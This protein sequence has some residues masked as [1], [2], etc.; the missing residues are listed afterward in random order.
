MLGGNLAGLPDGHGAVLCDRK[1]LGLDD[2]FGLEGQQLV[3]RL[4]RLKR[5]DCRLA[6]ADQ[7]GERGL[8]R[9]EIVRELRLHA[10]CGAH[11]VTCLAPTLDR[12]G[13]HVGSGDRGGIPLGVQS[14][15]GLV[16]RRE[17]VGKPVRLGQQLLASP[18]RLPQPVYDIEVQGGKVARLVQQHL[19]LVVQL[20]D[21][22]VG[23]LQRAHGGE[24][25]L[26]K[27]GRIDDGYRACASDG[28]GAEQNYRV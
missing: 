16:E 7:V 25:V 13:G 3:G 15:K 20:A 22:V 12:M 2:L 6:L 27:V 9:D 19:G 18:D 21:L 17:F 26:D 11:A 1:L 8:I 23:H 5:P 24:R 14:G 10:K 4:C 28:R